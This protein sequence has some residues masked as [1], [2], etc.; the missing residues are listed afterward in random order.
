MR[1]D[2]DTLV[3]RALAQQVADIAA[4]D[5]QD[6]RRDL[7]SRHNSLQRTRP[8]IYVRW[9][10]CWREVM[11]AAHL[12]CEDPFFRHYED[13][14]LQ[15]IYQ[16]RVGDDFII[17]PWIAVP[18]VYSAHTGAARWGPEIRRSARTEDRGSWA[19]RPALVDDADLDKMVAPAHV[20]DEP[21]TQRNAA[22][23]H[24]A[25]GDILTVCIDRVPC[26]RQWG[27]DISTDI[28]QLMGLEQFMLAMLDRPEWL[29]RLLG[30]MRDGILRV[31]EQ[32]E[33]AGDWGLCNHTNQSMPYAEELPRPAPDGGGVP[34]KQ[35]WTFMASQE[36]TLVSPAMFEEFVLQYQVPITT[37]FGLAAYGCCED[38]TRKI[39]LLRKIPNL[40]RIA[41]TPWADVA[42]CAA[43]IGTDY[44][45]SWRPSPAE[46]ICRGFEPDRVRKLIRQGVDA[47]GD[48]HM[49]ICLKDVE[50]IGGHFDNLIEWT[51]IVKE[52]V[53]DRA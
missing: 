8:L 24:E 34:R 13:V 35:L 32:A 48:C 38:L 15:S 53:H 43:Q 42:S 30:F 47:C 19:F 44:V 14:L 9:F 20:I 41:V 16:D 33:Q 17:E 7:W 23:L 3:L 50:T 49:D 1:Q 37:P 11:P 10:A 46:M 52:I 29:H 27:Q 40:R 39:D 2:R 31:H 4:K 28:A 22:R 25:I 12:R 6:Q 18:A 51:R 5:V 26:F 45:V 36:T 21:A